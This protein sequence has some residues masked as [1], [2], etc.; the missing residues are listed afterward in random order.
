MTPEQRLRVA[1]AFWQAE[2]EAGDQTH[3]MMLIALRKK[4]RPKSVVGFDADR[5]AR[6]LAGLVRVPD[7]IA[8]RA[9]IVYH[10]AEH[11]LMMGTFLDALG[12]EHEDGLI[13]S[14]DVKP[15]ASKI[16][17]AASLIAEQF[18][19]EDVSL[20]LNTL[21]CQDPEVWGTLRELPPVAG[22]SGDV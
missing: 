10:L 20:Y 2:E 9:L 18:P 11:R 19:A 6:L 17:P 16:A 15:D 14:E 3:A 13:K 4:F 8:G 5:K 22:E 21:V 12:I 7:S 1:R